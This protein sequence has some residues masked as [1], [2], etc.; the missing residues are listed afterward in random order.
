[1]KTSLANRPPTSPQLSEQDAVATSIPNASDFSNE[2]VIA[3][4]ALL[5]GLLSEVANPEL[6]RFALWRAKDTCLKAGMSDEAYT[7]AMKKVLDMWKE[8]LRRN[9]MAAFFF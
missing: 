9:P 2:E 3:L 1:M 5:D 6:M 8:K 7:T 4:L